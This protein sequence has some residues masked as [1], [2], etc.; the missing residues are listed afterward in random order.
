MFSMLSVETW[1][2][3]VDRVLSYAGLQKFDLNLSNKEKIV[4]KASIFCSNTAYGLDLRLLS[5]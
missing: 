1:A 4:S 3:A 2:Q 5:P